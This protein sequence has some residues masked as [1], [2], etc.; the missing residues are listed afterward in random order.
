MVSSLR[1]LGVLRSYCFKKMIKLVIH[2]VK[3]HKTLR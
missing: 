3:P 2:D 1:D